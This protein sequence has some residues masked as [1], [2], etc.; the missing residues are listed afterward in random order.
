MLNTSYPPAAIHPAPLKSLNRFETLDFLLLLITSSLGLITGFF[1]LMYNACKKREAKIAEESKSVATHS[2]LNEQVMMIDCHV[3]GDCVPT[4][5][6]RNK[7]PNS[8]LL[9]QYL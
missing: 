2:V 3:L 9:S 7:T 5:C 6:C 1:F 8:F 4:T